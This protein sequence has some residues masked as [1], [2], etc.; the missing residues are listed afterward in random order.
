V[1]E[2]GAA[3]G[4]A[5]NPSIAILNLL[6]NDTYEVDGN[7][8][9]DAA[10]DAHYTSVNIAVYKDSDKIKAEVTHC[11]QVE[12]NLSKALAPDRL[13]TAADSEL[14]GVSKMMDSFLGPNNMLG[15]MWKG[16]MGLIMGMQKMFGAKD[17][18]N[19]AKKADKE[20]AE[21]TH[22]AAE[23]LKERLQKAQEKLAPSAQH[24]PIRNELLQNLNRLQDAFASFA[25]DAEKEQSLMKLAA[26]VLT[27]YRVCSEKN[28][29]HAPDD[30]VYKQAKD[31]AMNEVD[32]IAGVVRAAAA[33]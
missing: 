23:E 7:V 17:K 13:I 2:K 10:H 21:K 11:L 28:N 14:D 15:N 19:M 5:P 12:G 16:V 29:W 31:A 30:A 32:K 22:Q 33:I 9:V 18:E 26:P 6:E 4:A 27:A 20:A 25:Y 3:V 24:N 1:Q 8:A